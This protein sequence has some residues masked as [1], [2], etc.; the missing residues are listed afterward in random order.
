MS[1]C[2]PLPCP[3]STGLKSCSLENKVDMSAKICHPSSTY[4]SFPAADKQYTHSCNDLMPLAVCNHRYGPVGNHVSLYCEPFRKFMANCI[5]HT[6]SID[7][8][9]FAV[10]LCANMSQ[11]FENE[12]TKTFMAIFQRFCDLPLSSHQN[13]TNEGGE[14]DLVIGINK[15]GMLEAKIEIGQGNCD[16]YTELIGY[17][18]GSLGMRKCLLEKCIMPACLL[19]LV[20]PH[21]FISGAVLGMDTIYVDRL[22]PGLWLV[23]QH[24][25]DMIAIARVLGSLRILLNDLQDYYYNCMNGDKIQRYPFFQTFKFEE[26]ERTL[27]YTDEIKM[28]VFN[29]TVEGLGEVVVKFCERYCTPRAGG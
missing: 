10:E 4:A 25:A 28:H 19:E 11:Y 16:S 14:C 20:G 27:Q 18:T 21:F 23:P 12:R 29:A 15:E 1:D 6:P 2:D 26:I 8:I 9:L 17:Y 3:S 22:A 13:V 5:A 24:D 7:D